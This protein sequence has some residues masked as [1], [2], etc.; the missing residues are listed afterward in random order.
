LK[1]GAF[2]LSQTL[3]LQTTTNLFR[4]ANKDT[5][6]KTSVTKSITENIW[7]NTTIHSTSCQK[8]LS[9]GQKT[10]NGASVITKKS[11][12]NGTYNP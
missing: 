8:H 1:I 3:H 2:A 10:K 4:S 7:F 9:L 12:T 5:M 6:M 11:T